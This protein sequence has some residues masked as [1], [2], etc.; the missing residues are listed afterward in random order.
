MRRLVFLLE[1][2]SMAEVLEI[3][4]PKFFPT[5][6][7]Q[8]VT[9]RGKQDLLKSIPRKLRAWKTPGDSF[10]ILHDNDGGDCL[11]LKARL[12][13]LCQEAGHP[14]TL[15]RIVCQELEAWFLADVQAIEKAYKLSDI[16][17]KKLLKKSRN[18]DAL[19]KPSCELQKLIPSYGKLSGSRAIAAY[20]DLSNERSPSFQAFVQ[21]IQHLAR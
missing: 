13:T 10:V 16:T 5:I 2:A 6:D 14:D 11:H 4:M 19:R 12:V 15:V 17:L 21:G 7:Y 20:L 3:I 1:E 9:H 8:L 18:P